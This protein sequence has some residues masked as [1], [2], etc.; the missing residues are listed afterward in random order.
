MAKYNYSVK[1]QDKIKSLENEL[2]YP[3]ITQ[4]AIRIEELHQWARD[5]GYKMGRDYSISLNEIS[6]N[7]AN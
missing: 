6:R 1:I 3:T 2:F 5:N 7:I 4:A